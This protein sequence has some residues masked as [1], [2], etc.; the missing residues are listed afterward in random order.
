MV[1]PPGKGPAVFGGVMALALIGLGVAMAFQHHTLEKMDREVVRLSRDVKR[2]QSRRPAPDTRS[3]R[4]ARTRSTPVSS[5]RR[6]RDRLA[7]LPGDVSASDLLEDQP[8]AVSRLLE[9][10]NLT[11]QSADRIRAALDNEATEWVRWMDGAREEGVI[12][13][14]VYGAFLSGLM[15]NT[16][17]VVGL[18]LDESQRS[19][20]ERWRDAY[21]SDRYF[22]DGDD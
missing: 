18:L 17:R 12:D 21:Q 11:G 10:L 5:T 22:A 13:D 1:A 19:F 3:S 6:L 9:D 7:D 14:E 8:D 15:R 4:P 16:D 2:L 20:Y